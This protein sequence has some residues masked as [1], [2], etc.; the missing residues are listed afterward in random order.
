VHALK[1]ISDA[2]D[3]TLPGLRRVLVVLQFVFSIGLLCCTFVIQQ[4]MGYLREA[5]LGFDR[6]QV[7]L[8]RI[9][10]PELSARQSQFRDR[11]Q[12]FPGVQ[13]V[14]ISTGEP[15]GF[16]DASTLEVEGIPEVT[17]MR[18]VFTDFDYVSTF[19][20]EIVA[21]RDFSE[22]FRTDSTEAAL[23]NE[24]AVNELGLT[25]E[26]VIGRTIT[27]PLFDP[28]PRRIVGVV[29]N[30][31]FSS[32]HDV[33]EPLIL[34]TGFRGRVIAV[35]VQGDRVQA[36]IE[37]ARETWESLSPAYPF[38]YSFLDDRLDRLYAGEVR[39]S[40]IFGLFA[41][42]AIFIACLGI[43]GLATHAAA[44]RSKEIGIRKVLGASV[45]D[46]VVL[47]SKSF[48]T[49]V[50]LAALV[51]IPVAYLVMQRWLDGFGYHVELCAGV[52]IASSFLAALV[53]L[54]VVSYRSSRAALA[55]PL[56]TLRYE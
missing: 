5:N 49:Q 11:L 13:H 37:A 28:E 29:K 33:I 40:R 35:K 15:G 38:T 9:S 32:L 34:S 52:F 10:N 44:R 53:A 31:N 21:G 41:G 42:I 51:A 7:L 36:V 20:L 6:E 55:N 2:G 23:L 47:L 8:I 24:F 27:N 26:E 30:Y 50:L 1:G 43:L 19:G 16:H 48:L 12:R 3:R 14:S 25:N 4:Q 56:E 22:S 39:Q 54:T 17:R 46:L 18:T 45:V